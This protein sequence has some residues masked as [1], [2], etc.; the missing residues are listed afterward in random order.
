MFLK[1]QQEDDIATY[2]AWKEELSRSNK[3]PEELLARYEAAGMT[4][5]AK[6]IRAVIRRMEGS[7]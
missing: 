6:N 2:R 5:Y 1:N 3:T 7:D 4:D